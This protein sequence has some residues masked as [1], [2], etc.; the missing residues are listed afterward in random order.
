[1][2]DYSPNY[3]QPK[4]FIFYIFLGLRSVTKSIIEIQSTAN[5][6]ITDIS[7][8]GYSQIHTN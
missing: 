4:T 5:F 8:S 2:R 7:S 3:N 1:M 6:L